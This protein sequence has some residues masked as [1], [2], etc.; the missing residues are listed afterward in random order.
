MREHVSVPVYFAFRIGS[1]VLLLKLS[2]Q[3]LSVR[4][5]AN[6]AQFLAFS[7]LLNMAVVAGAQNGLIRESAAASTDAA[8]NEV[9]GAAL[10]IWVA[11]APPLAISAALF[12]E[13]ISTILTGAPSYWSVVIGVTF[14]A[15]AAGPGQICWSI[16]TGRNRVAQ[17]LGAQTFGLL[18]GTG[19]AGWFIVRGNFAM[20]ALG[21][22][23][24][25]VVGTLIALPF[26]ARLNLRWK[27]SGKGVRRQLKYSAA[28]A[29]TLGFSTLM[30]FTLR[31]YYRDRFGPIELGYWLAANRISDMST[32]L[33]ALFML[34]LF[35]PQL[36]S[37]RD[38]RE[39]TRL[40]VR[41]GAAGAFL[42]GAALIVFTVASR[43]LV[44]LFLSD[45]YVAAIPGMRLYMLG[46]FF[47]V[48]V[49]IAMFTAFAAG[50]PARYAAI[51][52]A[53]LAL[54]ALLTVILTSAG[55]AHGPQ[56]A[57][58]AAYCIA[59]I[60][61]GARLLLPSRESRSASILS[62]QV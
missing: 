54:M 48:W 24:G 52:I 53:T 56:I 62:S 20:A 4:D 7:A 45:T 60:A 36:A 23:C 18:S 32:Q 8:L 58:A 11:V 51:E 39:R 25:P 16:L 9:L 38:D 22:A 35:V 55:E 3:F 61:L 14:L 47:R 15:L 41:Y 2:T 10:A 46:D 40:I 34:Q 27:V 37:V 21:F 1:A 17:S 57:Y 43:S 19:I 29:S 42:T 12:S 50:K 33:V 5:F 31:W 59:A 13:Q 26:V 44:H 28:I 6:F 49:S 30:L